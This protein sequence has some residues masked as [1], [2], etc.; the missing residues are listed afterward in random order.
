MLNLLADLLD[1][2][3]RLPQNPVITRRSKWALKILH[4]AANLDNGVWE[5]VYSS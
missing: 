1:L 4:S 3:E 5:T 2:S